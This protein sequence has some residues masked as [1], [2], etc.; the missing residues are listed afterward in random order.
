MRERSCAQWSLS[1]V[2]HGGSRC[3]GFLSCL[4]SS[5]S[6]ACAQGGIRC[7]FQLSWLNSKVSA[8][9]LQRCFQALNLSTHRSIIGRSA[10]TVL[11]PRHSR[12]AVSSCFRGCGQ[13]RPSRSG[14]LD[15]NPERHRRCRG[16][17]F[18]D[19]RPE[20]VGWGF[21]I[22]INHPER[23]R[24]YVPVRRAGQPLLYLNAFC[25]EQPPNSWRKRLVIVSDGATCYWQA[26]YDPKRKS[27]STLAINGRG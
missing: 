3:S 24:Q 9:V 22:H 26:F 2:K 18:T 15:T 8:G 14:D 19:H 16:T 23:F 27:Y 17:H 11:R 7:S 10:V 4:K 1:S 25:D 20:G 6:V 13:Q 12:G 21:E 5:M